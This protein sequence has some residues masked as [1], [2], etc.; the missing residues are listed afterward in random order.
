MIRFLLVKKN[1]VIAGVIAAV[2]LAV[3]LVAL[4]ATG[5]YAV[6]AGK[7]TRKLP[8]YSVQTEEKKVAL[9][10]DASWGAD[11]TLNILQTLTDYDVKGTFFSV[12]FWA[13]KYAD[14]LKALHESG[15]FEI[16]THSNTHP[17][18]SKLTAAQIELELTSSINTIESIIGVK[19]TLFR[20]PFGD[21]NDTLIET[22]ESMGL[23][24][25][26][27]DVDTLDW[28]N[29]TSGEIAARVLK[30]AV[31][32]SIILMHNDGKNTVAALPLIIEGLKNKGYSFVTV[33]EL[34]YKDNYTIDHSGKQIRNEG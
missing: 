24:T 19:P 29:L 30:K 31:S 17:H 15:R 2:I 6:Y 14:K 11:N 25:I 23:Y 26:Q 8:I 32:G 7:T 3:S 13:E 9:T 28:K 33:G 1:H 34:I 27:W 5:A 4:S 16:G 20:P 10:F 21:Y 18:M 22:A 12:G